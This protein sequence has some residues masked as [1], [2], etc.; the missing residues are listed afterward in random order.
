M[1]KKLGKKKFKFN[2]RHNLCFYGCNAYVDFL[3]E[4]EVLLDKNSKYSRKRSS[5]LQQI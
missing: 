4:Q 5:E 1:E 3:F 2:E